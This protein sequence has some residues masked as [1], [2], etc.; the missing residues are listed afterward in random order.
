MKKIIKLNNGA[1]QLTILRDGTLILAEIKR[2]YVTQKEL[3]I[4]L[5][6]TGLSYGLSDKSLKMLEDGY[7]GQ[8]FLSS[9]IIQNVPAGIWSHSESEIKLENIVEGVKA[10]DFKIKD[11]S[12]FVKKDERIATI[13][14]TPKTILRYPDGRKKQLK[15]LGIDAVEKL[16]GNNVY[17][18]AETKS[19]LSKVEG[20][21]NRS[22]YGIIS[23]YPE[24]NLRSI[25]KGHGKVNEEN[26]LLIEQDILPSSYLE[27]PSNIIVRGLIKSSIVEAEGNIISH[28]G[29]E[30]TSNSD[31]ASIRAGQSLY[32]PYLKN[33][34]V[35]AGSHILV[36]KHIEDCALQC[37]DTIASPVISGCTVRVGNKL[38]V[39]DIIKESKI[40]LGNLYVENEE[41][42][43]KKSYHVQHEKRITDLENEIALEQTQ[44]EM[45]RKKVVTQIKK[46]R[47]IS[48]N[49][50][51]SDLVLNRFFN[52]MK[53]G[54]NKLENIINKYESTLDLFEKERMELSFFEQQLF[55][56][57]NPEIIV[58]G[59]IEPGTVITAPNQILNINEEYKQVSIKLDKIRGILHVEPL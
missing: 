31:F 9:A 19:I 13:T 12:F 14:S 25:G 41:L 40:Y 43:N 3:K 6:S 46:L 2:G 8:I 52:T 33:Y 45:N 1:I 48:E 17:L 16:C 32:T 26:A 23:V 44:I 38:V 49:S 11:I 54:F 50:F 29:I 58:L 35:W 15:D 28:L 21:L 20:S 34:P 4:Y 5:N 59:R 55:N 53:D 36:N 42:T 57:I 24:K 27:S 37:L 30:N 10:E 7:K 22:I 56:D 47:K 39:K 51:G 18:N